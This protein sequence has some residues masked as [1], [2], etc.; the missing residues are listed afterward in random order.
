MLLVAVTGVSQFYR[1]SAGVIAPELMRDL[2]LGPETLGLASA[3]LFALKPAH[4]LAA[5]PLLLYAGWRHRDALPWARLPAAIVLFAVVALSSHVQAWSATGNPVFP[6]FNDVFASP[7]NRLG[8]AALSDEQLQDLGAHYGARYVIVDQ[9]P[10]V[11]G[12][13]RVYPLGDEFNETFVIFD[14]TGR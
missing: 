6:L 11:P 5:L 7:V 3:A 14:L 4:G 12:L 8:Y 9:L 2:A 1:A 10:R 13:R